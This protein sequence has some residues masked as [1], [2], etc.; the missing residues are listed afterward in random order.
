[1]LHGGH[2]DNQDKILS[3]Y[4]IKKN[5]DNLNELEL[6]ELFKIIKFH[7]EKYSI[8]NNGIFFSLTN[9][10]DKAKLDISHFIKFC[11]S[12]RKKLQ[13]DEEKREEFK[14][15]IIEE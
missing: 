3:N 6:G 7:N 14:K 10:S 1:M 4:D 15:L 5:I 11:N 8:N 2:K 13:I 9:L 12:N